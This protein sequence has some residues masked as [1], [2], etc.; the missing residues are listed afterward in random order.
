MT[1]LQYM[2]YVP[3]RYKFQ[4]EVTVHLPAFLSFLENLS[5]QPKRITSRKDKHTNLRTL[6]ETYE[7]WMRKPHWKVER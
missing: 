5:S 6:N 3:V 4:A 1:D 2:T 7:H